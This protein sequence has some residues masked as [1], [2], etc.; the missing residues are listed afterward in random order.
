MSLY[1]TIKTLVI[2]YTKSS[3]IDLFF[4]QVFNIMHCVFLEFLSFNMA[5]ADNNNFKCVYGIFNTIFYHKYVK[6]IAQHENVNLP[7]L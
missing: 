4:Y 6:F 1:E 2:F 5:Q 7:I 3:S